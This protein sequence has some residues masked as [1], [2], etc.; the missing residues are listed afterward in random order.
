MLRSGKKGDKKPLSSLA[1]KEIKQLRFEQSMIYFFLILTV[2]SVVILLILLM[3]SH[4]LAGLVRYLSRRLELLARWIFML[5]QLRVIG[6]DFM[7]WFLW[8]R[9]LM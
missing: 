6:Q 8:S 2:V 4:S 7:G 3:N 1:E 9:V 5:R